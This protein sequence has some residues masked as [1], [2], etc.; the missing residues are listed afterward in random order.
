MYYRILGPTDIEQELNQIGEKNSK[1][2]ELEYFPMIP[3][4]QNAILILARNKCRKHNILT[5]EI[6]KDTEAFHISSNNPIDLST[7]R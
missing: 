1:Q 2:I 7:L 4:E 6:L 5:E 3:E